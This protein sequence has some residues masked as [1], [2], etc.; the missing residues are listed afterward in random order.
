M[1]TTNAIFELAYVIS[2]MMRDAKR[3]EW[4]ARIPSWV[5]MRGRSEMLR[6]IPI[7]F[8]RTE[9]QISGDIIYK[10]EPSV[11][12]EKWAREYREKE[13]ERQPGR[14]FEL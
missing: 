3:R 8:S 4:K 11:D 14:V 5:V 13:Q 6:N 7:K 12:F 9:D 2:E 1:N 10:I